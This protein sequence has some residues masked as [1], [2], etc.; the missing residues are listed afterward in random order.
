MHDQLFC[1][2]RNVRLLLSLCFRTLDPEVSLVETIHYTTPVGRIRIS[3]D[4][5]LLLNF[6]AK[7]ILEVLNQLFIGTIRNDHCPFDRRDDHG[8]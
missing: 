6:I 5:F 1:A 4:L 2:C 3:K 8:V 7:F